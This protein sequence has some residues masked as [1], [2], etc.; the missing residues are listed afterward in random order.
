MAGINYEKTAERYE[1]KY[2]KKGDVKDLKKAADFYFGGKNLI[3]AYTLYEELLSKTENNMI[4]GNI[5]KR[6]KAQML[7]GQPIPLNLRNFVKTKG[8]GLERKFGL[9]MISMASLLSALF[10]VSFSL[11]GYAVL[12]I[13][14]NNSRWIGLCLFA[15]GLISAFFYFKNKK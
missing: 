1:I 3:R 5:R 9:A 15:C 7:K 6:L 13:A 12:G 2:R 4:L 11:T 10:F 8:K 14:E